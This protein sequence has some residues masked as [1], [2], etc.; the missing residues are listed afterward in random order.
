ME[1]FASF[2]D[3]RDFAKISSSIASADQPSSVAMVSTFARIGA[4]ESAEVWEEL[5]PRLVEL[6]A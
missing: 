3:H 6:V 5:E 2:V 1:A 4:V